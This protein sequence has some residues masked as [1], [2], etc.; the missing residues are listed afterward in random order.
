MLFN[1]IQVKSFEWISKRL[2]KGSILW[3]QWLCDPGIC[4]S[5]A[6]NMGE[7][8]DNGPWHSWNL[9][10]TQDHIAWF[11]CLQMGCQRRGAGG[12]GML[13]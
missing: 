6:A 5:R 1:E 8:V 13:L 2:K 11:I 10:C 9:F 4:C 12:L 7:L 3:H